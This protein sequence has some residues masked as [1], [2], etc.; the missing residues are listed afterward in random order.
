M[1][2]DERPMTND[3]HRDEAPPPIGGTWNRLYAIVIGELVLLV[4]LFWWFTKAF[5]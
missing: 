4:L 3:Q 2:D 1:S 5:E